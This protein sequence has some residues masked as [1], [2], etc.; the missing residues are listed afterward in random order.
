MRFLLRNRLVF[1]G[2]LFVIVLSAIGCTYPPV[3]EHNRQVLTLS[4]YNSN[5][6][7]TEPSD[8]SSFRTWS[9]GLRCDVFLL[10]DHDTG[11][12]AFE[13]QNLKSQYSGLTNR[14]EVAGEGHIRWHGNDIEIK[15]SGIFI[16]GKLVKQGAKSVAVE[17]DGTFK[18]DRM[19]TVY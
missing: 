12:P 7:M 10:A 3:F 5:C 1:F 15:Q 11:K 8:R 6:G 17:A 2:P 4:V 19:V 18:E 9:K 14:Y 13:G 16:N